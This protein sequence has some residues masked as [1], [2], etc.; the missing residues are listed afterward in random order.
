MTQARAVYQFLRFSFISQ[1][2]II[3]W[4]FFKTFF[5]MIQIYFEISSILIFSTSRFSFLQ[6]F[7]SDSLIYFILGLYAYFISL[8][9][10]SHISTS[11]SPVFGSTKTF[12]FSSF[13]SVT[14]EQLLFSFVRE[15]CHTDP[16]EASYKFL[17][18]LK[19][20]Y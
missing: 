15:L 16:F 13:P 19:Q 18:M 11:V 9:F 7:L 8:N 10:L 3:S 4:L 12:N 6:Y 2:S 17:L 5:F 14:L 1:N 20:C